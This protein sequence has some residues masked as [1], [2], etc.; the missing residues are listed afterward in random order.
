MNNQRLF[1]TEQ[2]TEQ[3]ETEKNREQKET[4][5]RKKQ[6]TERNKK[7]KETGNRKKQETEKNRKQKQK[8]SPNYGTCFLLGSYQ[9][10]NQNERN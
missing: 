2:G 9:Q 8:T 1:R 4:G 7:Q 5:S 10:R 6:E 3:K